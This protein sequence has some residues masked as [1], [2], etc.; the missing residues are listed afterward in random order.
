MRQVTRKGLMTVAAATGVLAGMGGIAH[1]DSG[2]LA[3]SSGSPGVLSGNSVSAPVHVP[4]NVC[5]NTVNVIGVLN[6]AMGNSC[7]NGSGPAGGSDSGDHGDGGSSENGSGGGGS[8]AG[9]GTADSPGVG[10]GNNVQVPVD[11]PVNVCGNS[12]DVAG[13]FNPST[14]NSCANGSGTSTTPPGGSETPS[15]GTPDEHGNPDEPGTPDHPGN[16][17]EPGT[18]DTPGTNHPGAQTVTQPHG[19][20]QLAQTGSGLPLGVALPVGAG[21]LLAGTVLYRKSRATA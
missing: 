6:P 1:A 7:A 21:A 13:A 11:V 17:E 18:P 2:A 8:Q 12:V 19:V 3:S 14:G 9:G 10:S 4:V 20:E 16:P 5:G 15:T